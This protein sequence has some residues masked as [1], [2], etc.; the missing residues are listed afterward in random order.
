MLKK[1][2]ISVETEEPVVG[3]LSNF[4][5]D[6]FFDSLIEEFEG[7]ADY[8]VTFDQTSTSIVTTTT[9]PLTTTSFEELEPV[10]S[11]RSG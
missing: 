1:A 10:F 2:N 3:D 7:Q 9:V 11:F 8:D 5:G 6:A 4:D